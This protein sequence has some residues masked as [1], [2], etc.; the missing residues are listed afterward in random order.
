VEKFF[1]QLWN[2][3][4]DNDV[5]LFEIYTAEPLVP[6][7]SAFEIETDTE[8]LKR[9]EPPDIDQIPAK[10]IKQEVGQSAVKSMNLLILLGIKRNCLGSERNQLFYPFIR[11]AIKQTAE[12]IGAYQFGNYV[13]NSTQRASVIV[14]S[15]Y[16]GNYWGSSVWVTYYY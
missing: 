4:R 13:Q 16:R 5:T 1:S 14:N 8:K 7:P 2:V 9:H 12:I 10:L 3:H 15:I 11:R 6:K